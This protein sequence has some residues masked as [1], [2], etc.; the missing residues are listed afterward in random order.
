MSAVLILDP[1]NR[2]LWTLAIIIAIICGLQ[3][4]KKSIK[5]KESEAKNILLGISI[6]LL[7]QAM[8]I[9]FVFIN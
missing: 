5:N 1:V 2:F 7:G 3:F 4:L 6:L 9:F 8:S